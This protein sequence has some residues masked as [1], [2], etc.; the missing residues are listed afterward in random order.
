MSCN[1]ATVAM[2]AC[3]TGIVSGM[4][5]SLLFNGGSSA[6][7]TASSMIGTLYGGASSTSTA[8]S[9]G[10]PLLD[11]KLAQA[12]ETKAV[13]QQAKQP[14]VARDI[15]AFKDGVAK[16]KDI[17]TA[18]KN[19]NVMKVLLTASN[20]S[21]Y[22]QTPALAQ[23]ALLSDPSNSASLVNK[24]NDTALKNAAKSFNVAKNGLAALKDPK[25]MA[26]LTNGYSEVLWRQSLD[27]ATPGLSNALAF[28]SQASAVKTVDDILGDSVNR[29]VVL[30]ALGIPDQVAFQP[31]EAQENAVSTRLDVTKLKDPKLVTRLTDQYLLAMQ[32]KSQ[33]SS[34]GSGLTTLA[35]KVGGLVV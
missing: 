7:D 19:P 34:S 25:V 27:K 29:Q 12:N 32:Q 15:T 10:N 24:L 31:L 13:A 20:L 11:L 14:Q 21:K 33:S 16:A 22:I 5:Y 28:I 9:T 23:K 8:A 17:Q 3:V 26:T 4:N 35:V 2:G 30:T 1:P 18:L 6:A